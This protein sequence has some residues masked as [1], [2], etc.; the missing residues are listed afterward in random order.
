MV[1]RSDER[2]FWTAGTLFA[3]GTVQL[4]KTGHTSKASWRDWAKRETAA[5]HALVD[6]NLRRDKWSS[7]RP[8]RR[9]GNTQ[10]VEPICPIV[11]D[12]NGIVEPL[13]RPPATSNRGLLW[14]AVL[15]PGHIGREITSLHQ[16]LTGAQLHL[17]AIKDARL[18]LASAGGEIVAFEFDEFKPP[19]HN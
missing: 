8:G 6:F 3:N 19:P 4:L 12:G 18:G 17:E 15:V 5:K 14:W 13:I 2:G 9:A 16:D 10:P 11:R 7:W 1:L